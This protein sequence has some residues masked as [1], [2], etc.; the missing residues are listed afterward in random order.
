MIRLAG[1]K[2]VENNPLT[3]RA[4]KWKEN[5][6]IEALNIDELKDKVKGK[7]LFVSQKVDGQTALLKYESG[8][9]KFGSLG[10][11]ITTNIPVLNEIEDIFKNKNIDQ[12]VMVGEL[13]AMDNGNILPFRKSQHYIKDEDADKDKI[14]WFPFQVLE[15]N[16][17]KVSDDFDT[18][19]E[20]WPEVEDIFKDAEY[21]HPCKD[22]QGNIN[23][24]EKAWKELVE[25]EENEG[26]VVRTSDNEIYK[27][28]PVFSYDLVIVAVGDKEGKN[29]P[30]NMISNVLVA[31]MDE[32]EVFRTAGEIG[33]GWTDEQREELFDWA[34]DHKVDEDNTYIWVEPKK[35][36]EV[37]WERSNV[38]KE[39]A[40]K[41]D[42]G[43]Y[44][45]V[46]DK[47]VGTIVK[48]VFERY[49]DDKSVKPSDLRLSQI[50]NWEERKKQ[51]KEKDASVT[52]VIGKYLKFGKYHKT[53]GYPDSPEEVVI[54]E[55]ERLLD[56]S[57]IRE[58]DVWTYYEGIKNEL[59]DQLKGRD[60]FVV[61][62]TDSKKIY[63]RHPYDKKTEF[64]RINDTKDFEE[65]HSGRTVEYH[66]TMPSEAEYYI[67]DFDPSP[68]LNFDKVESIAAEIADAIS[69]NPDVKKTDI[70]YTGKRGFHILGYLKDP[71]DINQAREDLTGYLK[72]NFGDRE[73]LTIAESPKGKKS[74]LGVSPMKLN[75]GHVA[76]H[77]MR[78]SGLCC[79]EVP[80]SKL[81]SFKRDEAR[82]KNR[83]KEITGKKFEP[84]IKEK[85]AYVLKTSGYDRDKLE[86]GYNG[87]FVIH[88]H[89][90][91]DAGPHWDVRIEMPVDSLEKSLDKYEEKVVDGVDKK[92]EKHPDKP[93]TVYRSFV[94][95]KMEI[96]SNGNKIYLVE[97][98]DHPI[99]AGS[100]EG[101]VSEGYGAGS[102]EIYDKGTYELL[103]VD[104]DKKYIF[105]F[106]GDKLKGI[107]ALVKYKN[108]F[109]WIK[110]KDTEKYKNSKKASAIDYTRP[111]LSPQIWEIE[112]SGFPPDMREEVREDIITKLIGSLEESDLHRPYC[113][114][115][116][117]WVAG[118]IVTYNYIETSDV[119]VNIRFDCDKIRSMYPELKDKTD[120]DIRLYLKEIIYKHNDKPIKGTSHPLTFVLLTSEDLDS[121][122][123]FDLLK[124]EWIDPPKKIPMSFDPDIAFSEERR[125][126]VS[127][128]HDVDCLLGGIVRLVYDLKRIDKLVKH[129]PGVR[130]LS[131]RV[132]ALYKLRKLCHQ[133]DQWHYKMRE[134]WHYRLD[135][136]KE[137][138]HFSAYDYS[139]NW[140][141]YNIVFKLLQK[142]KYHRPVS[143]LYD[144]LK[145]DSYLE[146]IDQFIPN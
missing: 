91:K 49:R 77:S 69:D 6:G 8:K 124:N 33:T 113:W 117:V 125:L 11:R 93:G 28:K 9:A 120:K 127:I 145:G 57:A 37:K 35:I 105:D 96:P 30:K 17:K 58:I 68:E 74:A 108:G 139:S 129:Y 10:G 48:P 7:N 15:L 95:K 137:E 88:E 63:K 130:S 109:L 60:L 102:I 81:T 18:Y 42:D 79:M 103:D 67:V 50:P 104:G 126:A 134:M 114:L 73:D 140:E 111:T 116:K 1:S 62:K 39:P 135:K 119:D 136:P 121:D 59:I 141:F 146:V 36:V 44:K 16:G 112:E 144:R 19:V 23:E 99:S 138:L 92:P 123:L 133:L 86:P 5:Q 97:T 43:E 122:A 46:E 90:A 89:D 25:K 101:K 51:K 85:G 40:Y 143:L 54:S 4:N 14:H 65:Y 87:K 29:W 47:L 22:Y 131:K 128:A 71:K 26:I 66:V 27:S 53:A 3:E 41:Y 13:A 55:K 76:L 24:L 64:I 21:I 110:V 20:K 132:S 107:Y 106:K 118:S 61:I 12:A 94:D 84:E 70:R 45:K 31:F 2:I 38:K 100:F 72:D 78:V 56:G 32:D 115:K 34:Q 82:I 52:A 80:R 75:G 83:Y 142:W 98:E